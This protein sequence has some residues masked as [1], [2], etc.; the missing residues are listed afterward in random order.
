MRQDHFVREIYLSVILNLK[1]SVRVNKVTQQTRVLDSRLAVLQSILESFPSCQFSHKMLELTPFLATWH[2]P[3]SAFVQVST[4][5]IRQFT[6]FAEVWF[7]HAHDGHEK[8]WYWCRSSSSDS[9]ENLIMEWVWSPAPS[10]FGA[11]PVT[12]R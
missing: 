1:V 6:H 10:C 5:Q 2:S 12:N 11:S 4:P 7:Q 3:L 9:L 8:L